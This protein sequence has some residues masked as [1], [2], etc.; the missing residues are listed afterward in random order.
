MEMFFTVSIQENNDLLI[1]GLQRIYG[2]VLKDF[3]HT[4]DE[5]PTKITVGRPNLHVRCASLFTS[6]D[7]LSLRQQSSELAL[8][9]RNGCLENQVTCCFYWLVCCGKVLP[10]KNRH[11]RYVA[12]PKK[13][14]RTRWDCPYTQPFQ[15]CPPPGDALVSIATHLFPYVACH[16]CRGIYHLRVG[17]TLQ[18]KFQGDHCHEII[19]KTVNFKDV[20]ELFSR[21]GSLHLKDKTSEFY[22]TVLKI[23]LQLKILFMDKTPW[24]HLVKVQKMCVTG[25]DITLCLLF[26][27]SFLKGQIT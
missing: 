27:D 17:Y 10:Y 11:E 8:Q 25:A 5:T 13:E 22:Q 9:W 20:F 7:R 3:G 12:I 18:K 1:Q 26:L 16:I 4:W 23:G 14:G 15:S 2:Y 6:I 19:P 21:S 24:F